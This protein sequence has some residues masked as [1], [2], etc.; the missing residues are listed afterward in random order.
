M[1]SA[2]EESGGLGRIQEGWGG[3]RTASEGSGGLRR[4]QEGWRQIKSDGEVSGGLGNDQGSGQGS[5]ARWLGRDQEGQGELRRDQEGWGG[6][7]RDQEGY[8]SDQGSG[9]GSGARWLGRD[10]EGQ[11]RLMRDQEGQ[12]AIKESGK[13]SEGLGRN[14]E[15]WGGIRLIC[16]WQR[17]GG[18]GRVQE[19][20]GMKRVR[21][22][23]ICIVYTFTHIFLLFKYVSVKQNMS[24]GFI[25][26]A[27][28]ISIF[29][30][31]SSGLFVLL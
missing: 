17:S 6:L 2:A 22:R 14:H 20:L 4:S 16:I 25:V 5:G 23:W 30:K 3:I 10:Q 28:I 21:K 7:R 29:I 26:Y 31:F 27:Q 24:I 18:L 8:G 11:G 1:R 19:G 9:E 13:G 12:G 15:C